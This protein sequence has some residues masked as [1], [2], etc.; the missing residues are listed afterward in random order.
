MVSQNPTGR[1]QIDQ[2]HKIFTSLQT[3]LQYSLRITFKHWNI[4]GFYWKLKTPNEH[5]NSRHLFF[6]RV[7]SESIESESRLKSFIFRRVRLESRSR[8]YSTE[9]KLKIFVTQM[10]K[11]SV[12]RSIGGFVRRKLCLTSD[13]K[14]E[15]KVFNG[16]CTKAETVHSCETCTRNRNIGFVLSSRPRRQTIAPPAPSSLTFI[17]RRWIAVFK[18]NTELWH[19]NAAFKA[20]VETR[21]L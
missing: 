14:Y 1:L 12:T 13:V 20:G 5:V 21:S 18:I 17:S 10:I 11:S 9:K 6:S 16:K 8:W 2:N 15:I 4:E 3:F 7:K 19:S